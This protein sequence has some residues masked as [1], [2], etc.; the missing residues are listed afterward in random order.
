MPKDLHN[1]LFKM[2]LEQQKEWRKTTKN[3]E[4]LKKWISENPDTYQKI[5]YLNQR[6]SPTKLV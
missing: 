6:K 5:I 3:L 1:Y 4:L 2:S